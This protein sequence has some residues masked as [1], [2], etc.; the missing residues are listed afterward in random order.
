MRHRSPARNR[1]RVRVRDVYI[2]ESKLIGHSFIHFIII[3]VLRDY[4]LHISGSTTNKK[5]CFLFVGR[6]HFILGDELPIT[7]STS[8]RAMICLKE[9]VSNTRLDR[10]ILLQSVGRDHF[11]LGDEMPITRS[12][13]GRAIIC[14][15]KIV[16]NTRLDRSR[17]SMLIE[18][19]FLVQSILILFYFCYFCLI[20]HN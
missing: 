17:L 2:L 4:V 3:F 11:I 15:K 20:A 7:R 19:R 6:D 18:Y 13:S 9:I 8:A 12:T 1:A 10:S 14:L 16:S 5:K